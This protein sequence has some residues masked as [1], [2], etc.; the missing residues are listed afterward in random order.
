MLSI[1]Q[2]TANVMLFFELRYHPPPSALIL[3]FNFNANISTEVM[4][5]VKLLFK[6]MIDFNFLT[7]IIIVNFNPDLMF[8]AERV[9]N[10]RFHQHHESWQV[11]YIC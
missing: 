7:K 2:T 6:L 10:R 9:N 3:T 4:K 8:P 5:R 11:F 1:Y